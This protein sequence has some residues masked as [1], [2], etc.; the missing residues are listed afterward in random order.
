MIQMYWKARINAT[1]MALLYENNSSANSLHRPLKEWNYSVWRQK[2]R[3][4]LFIENGTIAPERI[5][6]LNTV[7]GAVDCHVPN[8]RKSSTTFLNI[9]VVNKSVYAGGLR[10]G[11]GFDNV[12]RRKVPHVDIAI[13]GQCRTWRIT[14]EE[15]NFTELCTDG[16]KRRKRTSLEWESS[17]D[18]G[19]TSN[20]TKKSGVSELLQII[21]IQMQIQMLVVTKLKNI[22]STRSVTQ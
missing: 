1:I 5:E 12:I 11:V 4:D 21:I 22:E 19:E 6:D 8:E 7:C 10:D 15:I 18:Q 20:A 14:A 2:N 3:R 16:D 9:H 13:S 17:T